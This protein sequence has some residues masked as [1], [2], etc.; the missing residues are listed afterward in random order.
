LASVPDAA[1]PRKRS[2]HEPQL[3]KLAA[4]EARKAQDSEETLKKQNEELQLQ[5]VALQNEARKAAESANEDFAS[6][7]RRAEEADMATQALKTEINRI[8]KNLEEEVAKS[9]NLHE[10]NNRLAQHF[11]LAIAAEVEKEKARITQQIHQAAAAEVEK[12]KAHI[13]QQIHQAAAAEVEKEKAHIT[14]QIHQAAAAEVEREKERLAQQYVRASAEAEKE[15]NAAVVGVRN[16]LE[17]VA[18]EKANI[19]NDLEQQR[20]LVAT[21]QEANSRLSAKLDEMVEQ[22]DVQMQAQHDQLHTIT[23]SDLNEAQECI[24]RLTEEGTRVSNQLQQM[25]EKLQQAERYIEFQRREIDTHQPCVCGQQSQH[26]IQ[27]TQLQQVEQT[28]AFAADSLVDMVSSHFSLV[29]NSNDLPAVG[30]NNL[31]DALPNI[32]LTP[33]HVSPLEHSSSQ[34]EVVINSH[35]LFICAYIHFFF[36]RHL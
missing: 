25:T 22:G 17:R 8:K 27:Q 26:H 5:V 4:A 15:R 12:E 24:K 33:S 19:S 2:R 16:D 14:Q 28:G 11:Q 1:S 34:T 9:N 18:S 3:Q 30:V 36:C 31:Q 29:H 21:L 10:M 32:S 35:S 20:R 7:K 23:Q 6:F 13:T